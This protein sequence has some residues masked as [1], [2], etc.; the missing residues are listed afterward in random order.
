MSLQT[1]IIFVKALSSNAELIAQLPAGGVHNTSIALPDK[2]LNNAE[3][4]YV[5]VSFDGMNNQDSTKDSSFDGL[6]DMV[7]IGIEIAAKTRTQLAE[8]AIMVRDTIREY[9]RQHEADPEDEDN[10]LIPNSYQVQA[11]PVQYDSLKPCYWQQL[12][13]QCDTNPD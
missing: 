3:V 12:V 5:I 11:Q 6:T 4:P 8:L 9:F 10:E 1:D 2:D 13:F 7:T